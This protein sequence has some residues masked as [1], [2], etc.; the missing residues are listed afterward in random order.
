MCT[1]GVPDGRNQEKKVEE[2]S[3]KKK[4]MAKD[5]QILMKST[6]GYTQNIKLDKWK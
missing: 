2:L 1:I 5:L 6:C 4:M 3:E